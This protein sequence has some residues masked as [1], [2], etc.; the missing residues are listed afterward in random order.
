[1]VTRKTG[2]KKKWK[3]KTKHIPVLVVD[4]YRYRTRISGYN[5]NLHK[6]KIKKSSRKNYTCPKRKWI[7]YCLA[8][9][10]MPEL[11]DFRLT[12]V[13]PWPTLPG[14]AFRP[15]RWLAHRTPLLS[16]SLFLSLS[17]GLSF[18][19]GYYV[20]TCGIGFKCKGYWVRDFGL[21][22]VIE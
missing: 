10:K 18:C 15:K 19:K 12:G 6:T 5:E 8:T 21:R 17:L 7:F 22:F 3:H 1:L 2:K 13:G 4:F 16:S 9:E 20:R 14:A 11:Q